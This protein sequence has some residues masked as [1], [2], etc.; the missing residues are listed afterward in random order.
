MAGSWTPS[1]KLERPPLEE[2]VFGVQFDILRSFTSGHYGWYWKTC[3]D[4]S[5]DRT[6]DV[7]PLMDVSERFDDQGRWNIPRFT[8]QESILPNRI[9]FIHQHDDRMIQIQNTRFIYNWRKRA[10]AYPRFE[11]IFP[12]FLSAFGEFQGFIGDAGLA[13]LSVNQWEVTYVNHISRGNLW[14]SPS[15]WY[16]VLPTLFP[17]DLSLDYAPFESFNGEWHHVIPPKRARLHVAVQHGKSRVDSEEVL[18]LQLT[19]RGPV[20]SGKSGWDLEPGLRLGHEVIVR[21]FFELMSLEAQD[22]WGRM[23]P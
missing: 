20:D 15:D 13:P 2:T 19:A 6:L 10:T 1:L 11:V 21:T 9:Q 5:W 14:E 8:L 4:G 12:E 18:I 23:Q 3:L 16:R 7:P 17:R 22:Y